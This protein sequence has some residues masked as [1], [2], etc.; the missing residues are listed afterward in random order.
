[1]KIATSTERINELFD[2]DPRND[3]SIAK[4]LGVTRQAVSMWR[5]GIRSPKKPML[6]KITEVFNVSI[7]WLMGF[8]VERS[9]NRKIIIP[10]TEL[11]NKVIQYMEPEDYNKVIDAYERTYL[12]M[13]KNGII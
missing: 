5:S 3:A 6:I 12:K 7:E 10:D 2:S 4:A 13:K 8:D 9:G 11:F 1:M